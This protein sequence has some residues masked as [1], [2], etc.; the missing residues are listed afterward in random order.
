MCQ[1]FLSK[2]CSPKH[3]TGFSTEL[4][5][6]GVKK[7]GILIFR[8]TTKTDQVNECDKIPSC[9]THLHIYHWDDYSF[10]AIENMDWEINIL[11]QKN[12]FKAS[13]GPAEIWRAADYINLCCAHT[14][15][16][17]HT[18]WLF[19]TCISSLPH[20]C[21]GERER[22]CSVERDHWR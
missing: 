19:L 9:Y 4:K 21:K 8:F 7:S 14:P 3:M 6:T 10:S 11:V 1:H 5:H 17:A 20:T 15:V 13:Q 2:T 18:G 22:V 12:V 16:S